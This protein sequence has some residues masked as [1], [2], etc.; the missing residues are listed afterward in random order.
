MHGPEFGPAELARAAME[1]RYG[2]VAYVG[3]APVAAF[4]A[5]E[6][7]PGMFSLWMFA[8]PAWPLVAVS[9]HRHVVRRLFPVAW[10][11]GAR[12]GEARSHERHTVAH[13]WLERLG[14]VREAVMPS[15]GMDGA[16][17]YL[18]AWRR[19]DVLWDSEGS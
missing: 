17:Y 19:S 9:V 8:T 5:I 18:Y 11:N 1:S 14:A 7:W 13:K 6:A 16:T 4:G 10:A 15:H 12:R 2:G 3:N